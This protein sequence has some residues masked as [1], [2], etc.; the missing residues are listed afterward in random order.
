MED[1]NK[2]LRSNSVIR[3]DS[4]KYLRANYNNKIE[5]VILELSGQILKIIDDEV[6]I[7]NILKVDYQKLKNLILN[8]GIT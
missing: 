1:I 8:E 5:L 6:D 4:N 2:Y 7:S 3:L